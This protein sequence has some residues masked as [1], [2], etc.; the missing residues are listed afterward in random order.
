MANTAYRKDMTQRLAAAGLAVM[1]LAL[2]LTAVDAAPVLA[3]ASDQAGVDFV[4]HAF[5][6]QTC[7]FAVLRQTGARTDFA[8]ASGATRHV[9]DI[10]AGVDRYMV[11]INFAPPEKPSACSRT[12]ASGKRS[13]WCKLSTVAV[14][15]ND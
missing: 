3:Q 12:P 14:Q 7:H 13:A 9:A 15:D 2:A 6:T 8:L 4:C 10:A 5:A 11:T 1:S